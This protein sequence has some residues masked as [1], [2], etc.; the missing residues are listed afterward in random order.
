MTAAA[1]IFSRACLLTGLDELIFEHGRALVLENPALGASGIALL[2]HQIGYFNILPLYIALMVWAPVAVALTLSRPCLAFV[3]SAALYAG[4]RAFDLNLP[5]WPSD[6][7]WFF[8][9][10]AWQLVFTCGVIAARRWRESA[11]S[12]SGAGRREP[13]RCA[14]RRDFGHRRLRL[15]EGLRAAA[16][17]HLDI[18]KQN[19]GLLRLVHFVAISYLAAIA[20]ATAQAKF[21]RL[22]ESLRRL[23]RHSLPVFVVG[24]MLAAVGQIA[25]TIAAAIYSPEVVLGIGMIY[26]TAAIA[27]SFLLARRLDCPDLACPHLPRPTM[28][29]SLLG[30]LACG[31]SP[32][33]GIPR[34]RVA[35]AASACPPGETISVAQNGALALTDYALR[36]RLRVLAIGSSSTEGVG[37]TGTQKTYPAQLATELVADGG[38]APRFVMRA[39]AARSRK[40]RW[41][42]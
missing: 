31:G 11:A 24:S 25:M 35:F 29:I 7:R 3:V 15:D 23:G 22:A 41:R 6:G 4:A 17:A 10:L 36:S 19:L 40:R 30:A 42:D 38:Q 2:G 37:A 14:G 5:N 9:P 27:V 34:R 32:G 28:V 33:L 21:G 13:R 18:G 8:N 26:T 20:S 1:L 12:S 16:S 39:S